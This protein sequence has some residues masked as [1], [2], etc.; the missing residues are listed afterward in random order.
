MYRYLINYKIFYRSKE[1]DYSEYHPS[2]ISNQDFG[3]QVVNNE[4]FLYWGYTQKTFDNLTCGFRI[5]EHTQFY[6]DSNFKPFGGNESYIKRAM[7]PKI[8][9]DG[10][11]Y[12]Y[13]DYDHMANDEHDEGLEIFPCEKSEKVVI[14]AFIFVFDVSRED[15]HFVDQ[16]NMAESFIKGSNK[17]LVLALS[18]Y[19]EFKCKHIETIRSLTQ[20]NKTPVVEI[21]AK[22]NIN[23]DT[24]FQ[25][26][27]KLVKHGSSKNTLKNI[28]FLSYEESYK[29]LQ[30]KKTRVSRLFNALIE[31]SVVDKNVKWHEFLQ[32]CKNNK[33]FQNY[34][35]LYGTKKS[36]SML[37]RHIRNLTIKLNEKRKNLYLKD[38]DSV[39]AHFIDNLALSNHDIAVGHIR[40]NADF[41]DYFVALP[42]ETNWKD[43]SPQHS[44]D[45]R[46]ILIPL[47]LLSESEAIIC[48]DNRINELK[49]RQEQIDLADEFERSLTLSDKIFP[50]LS[51]DDVLG[52]VDEKF[53]KLDQKKS[54]SIYNDHQVV[55]TKQ[56]DKN[57]EEMLLE[58]TEL[59]RAQLPG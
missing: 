16:Y 4:N 39:F 59:F 28:S 50:G 46:R 32:F 19:D 57:F 47:D 44:S 41:N 37:D 33:D 18:K 30:D 5:I 49:E 43:A 40:N 8:T 25:V 23:I 17:P 9:T 35:D 21:S 26:A 6:D 31:K 55:I 38:L 14:D 36:K 45:T 48:F 1:D 56:C 22:D 2:G 29:I 51:L 52:C 54:L 58:N 11:K 12:Q 42:E 20:R 15:I 53:S 3:G 7:K 27:A 13:I 24:L 34:C 10:T